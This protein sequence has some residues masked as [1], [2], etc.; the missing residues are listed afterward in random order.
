MGE[1]PD[2]SS[3]LG[4]KFGNVDNIDRR[5]GA[6]TNPGGKHG[7][8]EVVKSD[9]LWPHADS[10]EKPRLLSVGR[11]P[12]AIQSNIEATGNNNHQPCVV[13]NGAKPLVDS[14]LGSNHKFGNISS[15]SNGHH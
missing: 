8:V 3:G 5:A 2:S 6:T 9:S 12:H 11:V 15:F 1:L 14:D 10:D 4:G 7:N 13:G